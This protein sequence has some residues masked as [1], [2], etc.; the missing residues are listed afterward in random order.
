MVT[1]K[2][3]K[4]LLKKQQQQQQQKKRTIFVCYL[5]YLNKRVLEDVVTHA[6]IEFST[7][8]GMSEK[9]TRVGLFTF[10]S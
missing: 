9:V 3:K 6:T 7:S 4:I 2:Q 5:I 8:V 1:T 10:I